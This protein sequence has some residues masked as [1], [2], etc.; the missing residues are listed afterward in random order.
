MTAAWGGKD[1]SSISL[2]AAKRKI[3]VL[4][5][6]GSNSRIG[7]VGEGETSYQWGNASSAWNLIVFFWQVLKLQFS[8][9]GQGLERQS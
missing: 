7:K 6:N 9:L 2:T 3:G 1:T 8:D 5:L 4:N